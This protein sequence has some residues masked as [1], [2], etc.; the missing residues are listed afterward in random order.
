MNKELGITSL[1]RTA[2]TITTDTAPDGGG[3][4]VRALRRARESRKSNDQRVSIAPKEKTVAVG[5]KLIEWRTE[6]TVKAIE[7]ARAAPGRPR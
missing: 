7:K 4:F 5:K 1:T 6:Q 3:P 2:T